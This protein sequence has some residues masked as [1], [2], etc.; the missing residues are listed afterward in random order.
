MLIEILFA[1]TL[2]A[3][4]GTFQYTYSAYKNCNLFSLCIALNLMEICGQLSLQFLNNYQ[5][6]IV[7]QSANLNCFSQFMLS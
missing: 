2:T 1:L 6:I 5:I 4:I 3:L 7:N